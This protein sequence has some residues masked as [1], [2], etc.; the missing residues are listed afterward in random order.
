MAKENAKEDVDVVIET[1]IN[2]DMDPKLQRLLQLSKGKSKFKPGQVAKSDQ[3][4]EII[5]VILKLK[6]PAR[7][8]KGLKVR[9]VVDQFVTGSVPLS[10]I[11]EV[12]KNKNVLTMKA[13]IQIRE[14]RDSAVPEINADSK[15]L[16]QEPLSGIDGTGVIIGIVDFGCDFNHKD[17]RNDDGTS[18]V[19]FL[20]DQIG[21][22]QPGSPANYGYGREFKKTELDKAIKDKYPYD[23]LEYMLP[24][25]SHGTHVMGIAAGNGKAVGVPG[26]APKA[27]IIFVDAD[28]NDVKWEDPEVLDSSFGNSIRLIEGVK[29][30]FDKAAELNRPAVVNISLGTNGGAHD[31]ST[32]VEQYLDKL[33]ESQN[34]A[35]VI[36]ASNSH[37]DNI[38]TCG[39]IK[40]GKSTTL[41]W[42]IGSGDVSDNEVEIWYPGSDELEVELIN[43]SGKS[44]GRVGPG[45]NSSG[46]V[47]GKP[48]ILIANRKKDPNNHDNQ[49]DIFIGKNFGFGT[50]RVVLHPVKIKD[51]SYYAWIERDDRDQ[52]S[53]STRTR[54]VCHTLGSISTGKNTIVVGSYDARDTKRIISSFSSAGPTRDGRKKPELSAPGQNVWSSRARSPSIIKM[55]GTSMAA[56]AVTGTVAL[57]MQAAKI[58]KKN[59]NIE[60][61]RDIMIRKSRKSPP[62]KGKF[63]TRYGNGR[64]DASGAVKELYI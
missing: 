55:S 63:N 53:F 19:L 27:D 54:K 51:G 50:W 40:Q 45:K 4:E 37:E 44:M 30:I 20:W 39:K 12:R 59:L 61:I 49:I 24:A 48:V 38:H 3:G 15:T 47:N 29:Y 35:I 7:P 10:M 58:N 34:R 5:E 43:P 28:L 17:F 46:S 36:A 14:K 56:P 22:K 8:I 32:P 18:R 33:L 9:T 13:S 62:P 64:I 23:F 41:Y 11:E 52:S 2:P 26:V 1:D 42:V 31:G 21:G 60:Q 25:D 16:N 6:D 57:L